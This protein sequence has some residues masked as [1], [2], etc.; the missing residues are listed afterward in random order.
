MY[1]SKQKFEHYSLLIVF[2]DII[3]IIN[4]IYLDEKEIYPA[5]I[6]PTIN[7][8]AIDHNIITTS[9]YYYIVFQS[10]KKILKNISR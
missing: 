3:L 5:K 8:L 9:K 2:Y 7:F 10:S 4:P 6:T 1:F